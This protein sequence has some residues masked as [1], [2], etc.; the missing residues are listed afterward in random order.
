MSQKRKVAV[1]IDLEKVVAHHQQVFAGILRYADERA[2]WECVVDPHADLLLMDPD[3]GNRPDGVIARA[4]TRL[5]DA[6]KMTGVPVV[7]VWLNTPTRGLPTVLPDAPEAGRMAGRHLLAR[8]FRNFAFLGYTH[9]KTSDLH[10]AGFK[11]IADEAGYPCQR[12]SVPREYTQ[13]AARWQRLQSQT[14]RW[15]EE[16]RAPIGVFASHDLL[17]RYLVGA[18]RQQN[19][20]VPHEV[21]VIGACNETVVC[22]FARPALSSIDYG[23]DQV[24][25]QAAAL[26]DRLMSGSPPPIEP[27]CLPPR[28]LLPRQSSDA[29]I[30]QDAQLALALRFIAEHGH[31]PIDVEDIARHISTTRWTL[32][33][34]FQRE[35]GTTAYDALTHMRVERAK[36]ALMEPDAVLKSVAAECGFRDGTHLCRVFQRV[37][38][39]TPS[40]YR[41]QRG[42]KKF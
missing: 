42:W 41:E 17:G 11:Q 14:R 21:A 5:A 13:T 2:G 24:G 36:R 29:F 25:Y 37:E 39:V 16:I 23:F 27:I 10:F 1:M 32:G 31:E 40:E 9:D 7:N 35:L 30:V 3:P 20:K 38:G 12:V 15:L 8:G 18:C 26:L 4:T 34:M 33:R 28:A 19:L 6:S 22:E